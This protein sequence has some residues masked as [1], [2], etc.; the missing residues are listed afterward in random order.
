QKP[1]IRKARKTIRGFGI[2]KGEPIAL[3]V[4][5]RKEAAE[6]FLRKAFAAVNNKIKKSSI[7]SMGSFSFGIKEHLD[8]PGTRYNPELGIIG[9]DVTVHLVKPGYRVSKRAY[10]RSKIGAGQ[11]VS[12]D[13]AVDFLRQM[14][15]EVVEE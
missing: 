14:G 5:L 7:D 2:H 6:E 8:I 9:M 1:E 12:L 13:E 4:T 11:R 3:R 15:V 10:R